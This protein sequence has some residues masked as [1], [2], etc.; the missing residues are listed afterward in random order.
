MKK[1]AMKISH[2]LLLRITPI[3]LGIIVV[4]LKFI[5]LNYGT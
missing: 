1:I 3:L 4:G 5:K 2:I